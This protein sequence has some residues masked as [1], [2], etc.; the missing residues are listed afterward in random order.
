MSELRQ[1]PVTGVWVVIAQERKKR[2]RFF[3]RAPAR[4]L[5]TPKD[6]PF[7]A[8]N[9]A[10]TPPEILALRPHG[11]PA[12]GPGWELRV[13][14]NRFPALRVEGTLDRCGDGLYDRMNGIGAHEVIIESPEHGMPLAEMPPA[15]VKRALAVFQGR[16]RDLKN[17]FRLRYVMVFKNHG[18]AAGA[19]LAHTHSQL[20]ALPVVPLRVRQE[21]E[22]AH[23]HFQAKERCL[24]CDILHQE[25]DGGKRLVWEDAAACVV[26]PYASRFPFELTVYPRQ[27]QARFEDCGDAELGSVAAA[28]IAA[29]GGLDRTLKK[30]DYNLVLH[31]APPAPGSEDSFHWHLEIM[32]AL[33]NVAGF[34]WGSGFSINPVPPEEAAAVLREAR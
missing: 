17:D 26:A 18:P 12:N 13:V 1:D 23:R 20:V 16:I 7:C 30:P 14:P 29:L 21:L 33:G 5:T 4:D 11:G 19:T 2:P 27:H 6:C 25:L 28:L 15:A 3:Q 22:G 9:E 32:P 8:G 24:F 10:L 34:E 31:N